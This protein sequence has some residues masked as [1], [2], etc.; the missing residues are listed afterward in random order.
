MWERKLN[1]TE[2]LSQAHVSVVQ[3]SMNRLNNHEVY[4]LGL[5]LAVTKN[6]SNY[7]LNK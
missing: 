1:E 7:G 2:I 5:D 4:E 3:G 6:A